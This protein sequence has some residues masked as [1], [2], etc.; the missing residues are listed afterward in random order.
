MTQE[1]DAPIA[2][3]PKIAV[4]VDLKLSDGNYGSIGGSC[5]LSGIDV[6]ATADD[7]L[8]M[9]DTAEMTF[10]LI[11]GRLGKAV[12]EFKTSSNTRSNGR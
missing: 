12:Q 7:I 1:Q 5:M 6:D 10:K 3:R 9:L 4:S 8:E 11:R 2:A